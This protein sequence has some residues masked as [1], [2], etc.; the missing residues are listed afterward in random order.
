MSRDDRQVADL[1]RHYDRLRRS[2]GL[3]RD[4]VGMTDTRAVMRLLL[5]GIA[6]EFPVHF[7]FVG[8]VPP[9]GGAIDVVAWDGE[10]VAG[11]PAGA[12]TDH[13]LLARLI[14]STGGNLL[15]TSAE[16]T[17]RGDF[18][19]S[20]SRSLLGVRF[21]LEGDAPDVLLLESAEPAA[22]SGDDL[23]FVQDLLGTLEAVLLSRFSRSRADRE[24]DLLM[25]VTRGPGDM[26][27]D[28][29]EAELSQ[30]L[31]KILQ[32]ALSL[33]RCRTGAVLL[34]DEETGDLVVEAETFSLDLPGAIPRRLKRRADRPSGI[35]FRVLEDN[36]PY[37]ANH[38]HRDLH[39]T[40]VSEAT[41]AGL[42]VPISFQDRCIGVVLV[43]ATTEGHFTHDHQRLLENLGS[44]AASFVRRAQLYAA[45]REARG[46]GVMIKGRG[47]AWD[48]VEKR[49]ERASATG[50]T[51]CLR[52]ESG[53]GK[54][55]VA[56]SIHF[57]S[58]RSKA[59]FVVVN[60]AAIPSELLESELF[61]HVKGA[62]TGAVSDRAGCFESADGG[63]VFLDE[64]GDLPP[65]LQAK[66]LR[67]L[68][69]GDVRK[70][71][72]DRSRKVDVR[73]IAATSRDLETTMGRSQF[74]EDLYYRLMVVPMYLPPLREYPGSIPS[75][76]KQFV[77]DANIVYG[78][79]FVGV[80][81]EVLDALSR[82][83]F[84]GN[85]R[86]LRNIV[87]Q[88]VLMA[89]GAHITL[90]DLPAYLRGEVPPPPMPGSLVEPSWA[91]APA[92]G[93]GMQA[94]AA[95]AAT[96]V[97]DD[98]AELVDGSYWDYKALKEEVLRRFEARYLD[99]LL[100]TT[101]GNVTR[102]AELAGIH[103]VNLHRML[104]KR[105]GDRS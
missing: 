71:G 105:E 103:R 26:F 72:S 24:F 86:E 59:P 40:P 31:Q 4:L 28:L 30:L 52:G 89:E 6:S 61:G 74:R 68:Q 23:H 57:N 41:K 54:E 38:V 63:T 35:V 91:G 44:T 76:V 22:F 12:R 37:L 46:A 55:L 99:A 64:I 15:I 53:T 77:R 50:A 14:D 29:D 75:M 90:R 62:F 32:I 102:A 9:H 27:G 92:P 70:V 43:E 56:N 88:G 21:Q 96:P 20:G 8:R 67:V 2:V 100:S 101:D 18:F 58:A 85:V 19:R 80:T 1:R 66:L 98:G 42:A 65:Q 10:A 13:P 3:F 7:G 104:K 78:R 45:T 49:I 11:P 79:S 69:S 82:H 81:D 36:R 25:E 47:P 73:V 5:E 83:S 87:E 34:A 48:E 51:V 60:C 94:P 84:P 17:G 95:P 33:T 93:H 97:G 39:Y 16:Q